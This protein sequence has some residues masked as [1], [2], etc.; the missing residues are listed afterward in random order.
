M[1]PRQLQDTYTQELAA[2]P[3][4][5]F[6]Y[7]G[8]GNSSYLLR[9]SLKMIPGMRFRNIYMTGSVLPTGYEWGDRV[10]HGQA[11]RISNDRAA[12]DWPVGVLCAGLAG[13]SIRRSKRN[14]KHRHGGRGRP[15]AN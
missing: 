11:K 5:T 2:N 14:I 12:R 10:A 3:E 15:P 4:A 9:L 6:N 8:H 13:L 7:V 1:R